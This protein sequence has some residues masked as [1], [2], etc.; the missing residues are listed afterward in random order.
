VQQ[1]SGFSPARRRIGYAVEQAFISAC[2]EVMEETASAAEVEESSPT[3]IVFAEY[4]RV[5]R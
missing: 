2:A 4:L 3:G 5:T 1:T